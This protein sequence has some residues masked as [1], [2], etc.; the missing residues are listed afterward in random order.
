VIMAIRTTRGAMP[1]S[2][3]ETIKY[4]TSSYTNTKTSIYKRY[5]GDLQLHIP[6]FLL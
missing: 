5:K 1:A 6:F 4:S 2:H 3:V